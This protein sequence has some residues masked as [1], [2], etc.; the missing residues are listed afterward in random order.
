MKNFILLLITLLILPRIGAA[1]DT[2]RITNP[3]FESDHS[4]Q[5]Q[6]PT[7]WITTG[8]TGYLP[9]IQPFCHDLAKLAQHG[10]NFVSLITRS[11]GTHQGIATMLPNGVSLK[12]GTAYRLNLFLAHKSME[13]TDENGKLEVYKYSARLRI[14]GYSAN[15]REPELLDESKTVSQEGWEQYTFNL[16]PTIADVVTLEF[17]ADYPSG[18]VRSYNGL[19]LLDNISNII[20]VRTEA[21]ISESLGDRIPLVNGS[22]EDAPYSSSTP[23]GWINCGVERESPP[24]IQPGSF[25]VSSP[26]EDGK[27][28]LGM[29]V[30]D[31]KTYESISQRLS[32]PLKKGSSY[33]FFAWL[34]HSDELKSLSRINPYGEVFFNGPVALR[35]WGGSYHGAREEL[36]AT[37]PIIDHQTWKE[38]MLEL[39]PQ[40]ADW[41]HIILEAYYRNETIPPY[42]GNIMVDNCALY[43][44]KKPK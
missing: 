42:N 20:R 30:R 8:E 22:F 40:K 25:N 24:D 19:I 21:E 34:Y 16:K 29:V 26:A 18:N 36:L 17:Q 4:G 39:N 35:V 7:G 32:I 12:K 33:N 11:N 41:D 14:Y 15:G 28:Y 13:I 1:Q 31:N 5:E 37:S 23:T 9:C 2:I 3:S 10:H 27:T 38:Y 43:I 44:H 6:V